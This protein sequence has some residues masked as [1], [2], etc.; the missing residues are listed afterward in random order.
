MPRK[1]ARAILISHCLWAS[2][3][4][5]WTCMR[6][7]VIICFGLAAITI[8]LFW[9]LGGHD[10]ICFDDPE[11]VTENPTV[12]AGL[13]WS[14]LLW[15]FGTSHA[16]NWHP[17][18]WCSHMLDCQLFGQKAGAH[19]L[20][21]LGF[22]LAGTLLL[23]LVLN[24]MTRAVWRSAFV[25]ALFAWHPLHVESVAW[26]AER[27]DVLSALFFMLTL[28]AYSRYAAAQ[29]LKSKVQSQ[30]LAVCGL[31]AAFIFHPPPAFFYL[32]SLLFFAFGL[33]SKPMLVTLPFLLWLLDYWPLRRF[34]LST[35]NSQPSTR[36][37]LALEKLPFLALALAA[38]LATLH[39]QHAGGA[40]ATLTHWPLGVRVANALASY[41]IY[42]GK[43]FWPDKL[44]VFYPFSRIPAWQLTS[45]ILLLVGGSVACVRERRRR[46]YLL[47]GW[48]W[49]VGMLLPVIGLLRVGSQ[50]M[51]DRYTY[52]PLIGVFIALSWG[53]G[54][55]HT[56]SRVGQISLAMGVTLLLGTCL[57]TTRLQL[58]HWQDTTTLFAHALQVSP[59]NPVA[60]HALGATLA[61]QGSVVAATQHYLAA[62]EFDPTYDEVH[63]NLGVILAEQEKHV[64]ARRHFEDVLRRNP[65][66]ARARRCLGNVLFAEGSFAAA[67]AQYDLA[68]QMQADAGLT[69]ESLSVVS[70]GTE[71]SPAALPHLQKALELLPTA[72]AR[73]QV[74][75]AWAAQGK[76]RSAVQAHHTALALQPQSP[77]IL[78]NLAWI[79]ATC[80]KAGLRDGVE[81]VRLAEQA[82]ALT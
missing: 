8:A 78:N 22:H 20:V 47:V 65:R 36:R 10:F 3:P 37:R 48:C 81:A 21:S 50:A 72:E 53:I 54:E 28:W 13:N 4:S 14:S 6:R 5:E 74:A 34:E 76:S 51:A 42:L 80:P 23:F 59:R 15:A 71:L 58:Q 69:A 41:E 57:A 31:K 68:W 12:L 24:R 11:Y 55:I 61:A 62:L 43:V 1:T 2:L 35:L 7:E 67:V 49:F 75:S 18:T 60:H 70:P 27:K 39:A 46:P 40:V 38:G 16:S 29:A 19:H 79:L 9:P 45:S 30:E 17:L 64:E 56:R 25:A 26:V 63:V 44:S 66:H 82:C 77:E 52:L 32:L 33:M 73:E